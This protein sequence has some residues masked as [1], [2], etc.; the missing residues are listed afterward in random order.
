MNVQELKKE[1][2]K[3]GVPS[4]RY[5]INGHLCSDTHILNEVYY[6]WEY[7]Y[8][9]EKGR[10]MNYRRFDNENDACTYF[11][12]EMKKTMRYRNGGY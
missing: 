1:I 2:E 4:R 3:L 9:D 7:F 6:Y 12:E 11:L 5:S 8:M 10:Q